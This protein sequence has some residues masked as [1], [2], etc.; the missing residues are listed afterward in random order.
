MQVKMPEQKTSA[1]VT[2]KIEVVDVHVGGDVHRVVLGGIKELPGTSVFEQMQ[3]LKAN[4]DGLRKIL[5]DEPRGGHPSLFADLVVEPRHDDADFGFIIMELMGYPLISG[6]NTMSTVIALLE[7]GRLPMPDGIRKITLEAPGGLISVS[8]DCLH[9]KVRAVTYEA[10][11]PSFVAIRGSQVWVEGWGE[12]SFDVVWTGAFYPIVDVTRLGFALEKSEEKELV[13]FAT[14][15][16]LAARTV[17]H[18]IHP[19]FGDEG[20]LTFAIMAGPLKQ[21]GDKNWQRK[22]CCYEFPRDSVCRSPAGVPSTAA[23]VQLHDR[24]EI[25][26]G[27]TLQTVSIFGTTLSVKLSAEVGYC[28]QTGVRAA[29]TGSGWITMR[30]HLVV[31]FT[32]P[33][34]PLEGLKNLLAD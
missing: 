1:S 34:T 26:I 24:G 2:R 15:F 28:D 16:V 20:P 7:S 19:V 4:G 14:K 3:Y 29:V 5:L 17:C 27:E 9:G 6:T 21:D 10:Q 22:V 33:L 32:D 23:A 25:A 31:D 11:T 30:S 18:P 12:V 13:A 8:A